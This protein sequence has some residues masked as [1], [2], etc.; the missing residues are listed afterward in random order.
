MAFVL[1]SINKERVSEDGG[2]ELLVSGT[3]EAG[4]TYYVYI[5]DF[6]TSSDAIC[7]SGVSDQGNVIIPEVNNTLYAYTPLLTT[8]GT[9]PYSVTVIDVS[10]AESHTLTDSIYID[11]KQ[12]LSKIYLYRKMLSPKY[13]YGPNNIKEEVPT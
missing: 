7:Y 4:H 8:T 2:H 11:K 3:F 13:I 5:G 1:D 12:F 10:T 9:T 6:K